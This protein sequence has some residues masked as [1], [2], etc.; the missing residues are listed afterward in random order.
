MTDVLREK[1][2]DQEEYFRQSC[3]II[4]GIRSDENKTEASLSNSVI[5]IIKSDLQLPDV[6]VNG[7]DKCHRIRLTDN[8]GKQSIII[9]FTKHSTATKALRERWKLSK[10]VSNMLNSVL[11]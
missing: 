11:H 2:N 5:D 8:D 1:L 6:T 10:P 3:L 9:K 4:E 7:V